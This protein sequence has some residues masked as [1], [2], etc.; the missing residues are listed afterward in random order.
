MLAQVLLEVMLEALK[1]LARTNCCYFELLLTAL[2]K[3]D[4][5][6]A[7][8]I[9]SNPTVTAVCTDLRKHWQRRSE[10]DIQ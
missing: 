5:L 8:V 6:L 10:Q 4:S 7:A 3:L 9:E 1:Q 2:Y